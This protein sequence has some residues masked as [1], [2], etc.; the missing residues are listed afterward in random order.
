MFLK[1]RKLNLSPETSEDPNVRNLMLEQPPRKWAD[2][3]QLFKSATQLLMSERLLKVRRRIKA[4]QRNEKIK[5]V[6][7]S[8]HLSRCYRKRPL[9][10]TKKGKANKKRVLPFLLPRLTT[11]NSLNNS[12]GYRKSLSFS[13]KLKQ[14]VERGKKRKRETARK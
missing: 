8:L 14:E 7:P 5:R 11:V 9:K 3:P 12:I 4:S 2:E 10:C 13:A 1:M 6:C